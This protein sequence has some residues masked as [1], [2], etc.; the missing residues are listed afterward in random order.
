MPKPFVYYDNVS[1]PS[2]CKMMCTSK[3]SFKI[4]GKECG[5]RKTWCPLGHTELLSCKPQEVI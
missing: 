3:T 1:P 4:R 2:Q 5:R